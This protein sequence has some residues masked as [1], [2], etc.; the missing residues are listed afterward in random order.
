MRVNGGRG[1]AWWRWPGR[2]EVAKWMTM[3]EARARTRW[4]IP[5]RGW[6]Q[7][8]VLPSTRLFSLQ[9]SLQLVASSS[10]F[11]ET[12]LNVISCM[13]LLSHCTGATRPE[14]RTVRRHTYRVAASS[15]TRHIPPTDGQVRAALATEAENASPLTVYTHATHTLPPLGRPTAV[16]LELE[17]LHGGYVRR[18][19]EALFHAPCKDSLCA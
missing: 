4:N 6:A 17:A 14:R 18:S 5:G 9:P 13:V 3:A 12:P 10:P 2:V 15:P 11:K 19:L 8:D 16:S 7:P 1:L